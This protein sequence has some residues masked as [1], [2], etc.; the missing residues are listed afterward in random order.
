MWKNKVM[1]LND[2]IGS[3]VGYRKHNKLHYVISCDHGL[4]NSAPKKRMLKDSLKKDYSGVFCEVCQ[5][6]RAEEPR[7][8]P[9]QRGFGGPRV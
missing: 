1:T 2:L 8:L 9:V 4:G 7:D 6:L 3:V 5:G